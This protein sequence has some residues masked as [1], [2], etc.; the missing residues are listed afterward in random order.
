MIETPFVR[1][2][3]NYDM[4][5]AGD[6]SGL[7]CEDG[8]LAQQHMADETD[9]NKLVE[10]FVVTG[11]IP[12]LNMPPLQ[13]DFTNIPTYQEALNLMRQAESSFMQ[14]PAKIRSQFENDPGKFVDFASDD[15]NREKLREWGLLSPEANATFAAQAKAAEDLKTANAAAAEELKSLKKSA[16]PKG[17]NQ[18]TT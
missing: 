17:G 13:G 3:Y 11:E 18:F 16:P 7:K 8:S 14:L 1:S 4:N 2:P 10:R 12:Q 5:L 15:N 9:I 6:D